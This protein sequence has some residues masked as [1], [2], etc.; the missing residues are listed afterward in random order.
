[1]LL[2]V[3]YTSIYKGYFSFITGRNKLDVNQYSGGIYPCYNHCIDS[4]PA[5]DRNLEI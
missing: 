4:Y 3:N 5:S 1:M 2:K